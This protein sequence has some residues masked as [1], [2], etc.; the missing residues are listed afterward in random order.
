VNMFSVK[1][2]RQSGEVLL[3]ACDEGI[4]GQTFREGD[5]RI[6]VGEGF[7]GGETVDEDGLAEYMASASSMNLVGNETIAVA[8][9]EG[10]VDESC[11]IVIDGVRHAQVLR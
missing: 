6:R 11:L 8:I 9:R 4:L 10:H 3:A 7:Y 2:H 5:L 1:I